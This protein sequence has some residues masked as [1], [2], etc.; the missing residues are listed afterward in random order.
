M[1]NYIRV[2]KALSDITRARILRLLLDAGSELCICEI[3][4]SLNL[5]QYRI[6]KHIKELKNAGILKERRQGRFIFYSLIHARGTFYKYILKSV[7]SMNS[8]IITDDSKR[9]V[10]RLKGRRH[11]VCVTGIKK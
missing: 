1:E 8:R 9:L 4:D 5:A 11:G 3:V 2:F 10:K 7:R 6:S